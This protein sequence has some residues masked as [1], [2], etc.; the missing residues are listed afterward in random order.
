MYVQLSSRGGFNQ[1]FVV[2]V[3]VLK[4][5]LILYSIL[6]SIRF[7]VKG[8]NAEEMECLWHFDSQPLQLNL[9]IIS[10][11]DVSFITHAEILN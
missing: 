7:K 2:V 9:G 4:L 1:W 11:P 3:V 10:H 8:P 5:V 6:K